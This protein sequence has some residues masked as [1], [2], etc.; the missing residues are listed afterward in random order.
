[1]FRFPYCRLIVEK[2]ELEQGLKGFGGEIWDFSYTLD[3]VKL[4]NLTWLR[5]D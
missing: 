2:T 4:N 1:V 5:Y 3:V